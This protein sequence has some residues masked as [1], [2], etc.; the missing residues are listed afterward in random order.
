MTE[1]RMSNEGIYSLM[2]KGTIIMISIWVFGFLFYSLVQSAT[3][4]YGGRLDLES[5]L[6]MFAI[7]ITITLL[8]CF[9]LGKFLQHRMSLE[10]REKELLIRKGLFI[11]KEI[12]MPY[13]DFKEARLSSAFFDFIDNFLGVSAI[14]IENTKIFVVNGV[15]DPID[16]VRE[17]NDRIAANKRKGITVEDLAKEIKELKD[18]IEKL[19]TAQAMKKEKKTGGS[20]E[21]PKRGGFGWG[22]LEEGV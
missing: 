14:S 22:P 15:K 1:I 20:E 18:E 21:G 16:S 5:L 2:I 11:P 4:S 6:P 19:K 10:T 3:G 9:M 8:G 12:K 13:S 17:I 7:S